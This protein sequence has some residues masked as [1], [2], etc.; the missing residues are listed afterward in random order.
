M[1]TTASI[2]KAMSVVTEPNWP[3]SFFTLELPSVGPVGEPPPGPMTPPNG[4][5][6]WALILRCGA[7]S[8]SFGCEPGGFL[9]AEFV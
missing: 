7:N 2:W 8:P 4:E 9:F 3:L 5:G 1:C 6:I